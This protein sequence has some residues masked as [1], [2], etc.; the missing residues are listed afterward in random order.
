MIELELKKSW[1]YVSINT[2]IPEE[3]RNGIIYI[4]NNLNPFFD[5]FNDGLRPKFHYDTFYKL[6][7]G[8]INE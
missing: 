5:N 8:E 3:S 4:L 1:A 6:T 2:F 7:Q